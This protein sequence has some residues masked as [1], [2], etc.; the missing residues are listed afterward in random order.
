MFEFGS[1]LN[2]MAPLVSVAKITRPITRGALPRSRLFDLL[3]RSDA[4]LTWI[5]GPPGSGKTTLAAT[6]VEQYKHPC[7]WVRMDHADSD[8]ASFFLHI[9]HAASAA[10]LVG[11]T[12]LPILAPE[13]IPDPRLFASHFFRAFFSMKADGLVLVLDDCHELPDENVVSWLFPTVLQEIPVGARVLILS[14]NKITRHLSRGLANRDVDEFDAADLAF[15]V[16]ETGALLGQGRD[17]QDRTTAVRLHEVTRGW[18]AGLVL[19]RSLFTSGK[20][21]LTDVAR[22]LPR[23]LQEYFNAEVVKA[24]STADVQILMKTA[25]LPYLTNSLMVEVTGSP[26]G[27]RLVADLAGRGL[28]VTEHESIE[29]SFQF[30]P[31][32]RQMLQT[33]AMQHLSHDQLRALQQKSAQTVEVGGDLPGA[34]EL[35]LQAGAYDQAARLLVAQAPVALAQAQFATLTRWLGALPKPLRV[36]NSWLLFWEGACR[37]LFNPVEGLGLFKQAYVLFKRQDDLIGQLLACC[38]SIEAIIIDWQAFDR[39]D[40]WITALEQVFA[41]VPPL[42]PELE[43]RGATGMLWAYLWRRPHDTRI[44]EWAKRVTALSSTVRDPAAIVTA[45]ASLIYFYLWRGELAEAGRVYAMSQ[46]EEWELVLSP[47]SYF[48]HKITQ[49]GYLWKAGLV[50]ECDRVVTQGLER[51]QATG[52][53][54]MDYHLV[55]QSLIAALTVGD[56]KRAARYLS[57]NKKYIPPGHPVLQ[58]HHQGLVAWEALLRGDLATAYASGR[59]AF[60]IF[61]TAGSPFVRGLMHQIMAVLLFARGAHPQAQAMLAQA[62]RIAKGMKSKDI[63]IPCLLLKADMSLSREGL[64]LRRSRSAPAGGPA[65]VRASRGLR[66]LSEAMRMARQQGLVAHM[67][68]HPG[69]MS[70]LCAMAVEAG[71]EVPY[72][73]ELI[74]KKKLI[75][76]E[77]YA[78]LDTW[79]WPIKVYTLGRFSLMIDGQPVAFPGRT[80]KRPLDLLKMLMALGG[81]EVS[82]QSLMEGL[83]PD[84]EG[85]AAAHA[86]EMLLKRLRHLLKHSEALVLRAGVL[87]LNPRLCWVDAWAFERIAGQASRDGMSLQKALGLYQGSFL[88]GDDEGRTVSMRE[89]LRKKFLVLIAKQGRE[90]EARQEWDQAVQW[91]ERGLD[92]DDLAEEFYR[93]LMQCHAQIGRLA[94]VAA[95]YQRCQRILAAGLD[96][97]PSPETDQL[98]RRLLTLAG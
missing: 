64:R 26:D 56:T 52:V 96:L 1:K 88:N 42:S 79:A 47:I 65:R 72:V 61:K 98:Y 77:G 78:H 82:E 67:W 18:A 14:R 39:L 21:D 69:T 95:T 74:R 86:F 84:S 91:Y 23:R 63:L 33:I 37:M 41:S 57:E 50:E 25:W 44:E 85:D 83:W 24:L 81:R 22:V 29:T 4:K 7:V 27:G 12:P 6:Y 53:H 2:P 31:L 43:L 94:E 87:T 71:I 38:G 3:D 73:Q 62:E 80:Q 92:V 75:V 97:D 45:Q 32:F 15:T 93:R 49:S 60:K 28:F 55:S 20:L 76:P 30:H 17:V 35:W 58:A 34:I 46:H 5:T 70:R 40:P 16:K 89:R 66:I 19:Y 59:S 90:L 8:P 10:K 48:N 51:A 36:R 13:Q 68:S 54:L 11:P 9:L